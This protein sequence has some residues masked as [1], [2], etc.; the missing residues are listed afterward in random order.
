MDNSVL[1][2]Y[3]VLG[4]KWGVRRYQNKD[5]SL[6]SAGEKRYSRDVRENLAKKK[7]NRIDTSE[8]DP[9]RWV[10]EDLTRS[11]KSVDSMN[12]LVNEAKKFTQTAAKKERLDLSKMT[13][14]EL[15]QIIERENLERRYNEL[16]NVEKA[17]KGKDFVEKALS[18][19]GTTLAISSSALGIALA[20]KE[21]KG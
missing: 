5:G 12:D 6:T 2:H 21:L 7:E 8:P 13:D 9:S 16:F 10:K 15:R 20:I 1:V 18:V 4:M 3:G 19:A 14:K 17:S 11:K